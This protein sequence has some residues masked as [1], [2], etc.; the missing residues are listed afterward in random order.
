MQL[1]NNKH[2]HNVLFTLFFAEIHILINGFHK[3]IS[4][5]IKALLK[6]VLLIKE[7]EE[8]EDSNLHNTKVFDMCEERRK[9]R[10]ERKQKP[11]VHPF[12]LVFSGLRVLKEHKYCRDKN[13]HSSKDLTSKSNNNECQNNRK[14]H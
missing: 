11:I 10:K 1:F 2:M 4:D 3:S 7:C 5:V 12:L 8:V 13:N 14:D 9:D 6:I